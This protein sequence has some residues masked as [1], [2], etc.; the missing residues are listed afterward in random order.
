[1]L[2]IIEIIHL[3]FELLKQHENSIKS[4]I[5]IRNVTMTNSTKVTDESTK[6][7]AALEAVKNAFVSQVKELKA[8]RAGWQATEFS[9]ANDSLYQMLGEVFD[10][11]NLMTGNT[12]ESK[13]KRELLKTLCDGADY[14]FQ[15]KKPHI[16][17]MLVK[18]IFGYNE[19]NKRR[20][21]TYSRCIKICLTEANVSCGADAVDNIRNWGGVEEVIRSLNVAVANTPKTKRKA[22]RDGFSSRELMATVECDEVTKN[23]TELLGSYVVLVGQVT[24][25][26]GIE[27]KHMCAEKAFADRK[28]N[29]GMSVVNHAL[30]NMGSVIITNDATNAVEKGAEENAQSKIMETIKAAA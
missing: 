29:F 17:D 14:N 26:G 18:F 23:L 12:A 4:L 30:T 24:A 8:K 16:V 3:L 15:Q 5:Y 20:L 9:T 11:H 28:H 6:K 19:S 7:G 2:L 27:V 25:T 21:S 13:V 1:M 22:A 10:T